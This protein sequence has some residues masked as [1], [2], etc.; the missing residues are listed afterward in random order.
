MAGCTVSPEPYLPGIPDP[1]QAHSIPID[2]PLHGPPPGRF[3]D[4]EVLVIQY[5]SDPAAIAELVPA[6]LSPAGD[7]VMV[8]IARWGD[9]PGLGR[10]T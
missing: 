3:S 7:T 1:A 9:V 2:S 6:P 4:G 8:Q 10:D 5:R